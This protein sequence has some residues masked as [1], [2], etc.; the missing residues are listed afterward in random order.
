MK[1][2]EVI[3]DFTS[4]LDV[5][6]IILFFFVLYSTIDTEE[7]TNKAK[8][9]EASYNE[10]I[11]ENERKQLENEKEQEEWREEA[12]KEWNRIESMDENAA[13]NQQALN[14]F[15]KGEYFDFRLEVIDKSDNWNL[16][17]T[18]GKKMRCE[19]NSKETDDIKGSI[20]DILKQSGFS[21]D[22]TYLCILSYNG[23]QYGTA[24]AFRAIDEAIDDIQREYPN[25]YF[26]NLNK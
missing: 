17:I 20:K 6:M 10:L 16:T 7:V 4:L 5:I 22:D 11:E 1:I 24:K 15:D 14:S 3:L 23:E 18:Y 8:R 26:S 12:S 2:R 19:I 9:A 25:L 21:T 13:A